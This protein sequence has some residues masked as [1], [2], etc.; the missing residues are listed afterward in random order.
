MTNLMYLGAHTITWAAERLVETHGEKVRLASGIDGQGRISEEAEQRALECLKRFHQ[1]IRMFEDSDVIIVGTNALRI[2]KNRRRFIEKA[3]EVIGFPIEVISGREEARLIYLGV[4]HSLADDEG[5]RLVIDIGGGSTELIIGERFESQ[6]L[7]SLHMGCVSYRD[8]YVRPD[9]FSKAS[10]DKAVETASRELINIRQAYLDLGWDSCV[11]SSGSVKAVSNALIHTGICA[12][13]EITLKHLKTLRKKIRDLPDTNEMGVL[14]VKPD[15]ESTFLAGLAILYASFEVLGI[16]TMIFNSGALREGLL[17][18][19]LGRNAHEDV[20]ERTIRSLQQRYHLD[21][22]HCQR[23]LAT[24]M[25]AYEQVKVSWGID[26][27]EA[28]QL[29]KWACEVFELGFTISHTQHHKHGAYL[30]R[31][32]DL[33]GFTD[34]LKQK[35]AAIV[36]LHRRKYSEEAFSDL[37]AKEAGMIRKLSVLFRLAVILTA[38]RISKETDFSLKADESSLVLSMGR[39]WATAHP[40][41]MASLEAERTLLK[42]F[43]ITLELK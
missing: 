19:V 37:S 2:A 35:L 12:Q 31:H 11:G 27:V 16:K 43:D 3:E 7:E 28:K 34:L 39:V 25:H 14:G 22:E 13:G 4:S 18:D 5:R 41:T 32:S 20:R 1:R 42:A 30:L 21:L 40:L 8:R 33:P 17:Y 29:L 6:Q 15:R 10:F 36:R 23:V 38:N 26:R 24:A 9:N